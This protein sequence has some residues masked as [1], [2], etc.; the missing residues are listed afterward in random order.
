MSHEEKVE[1]ALSAIRERLAK[2]DGQ[3]VGIDHRLAAI[4]GR[5]VTLQFVGALLFAGILGAYGA[6][7]AVALRY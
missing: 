6:I 4:E 5:L 7:L 1:D 3:L 2:V